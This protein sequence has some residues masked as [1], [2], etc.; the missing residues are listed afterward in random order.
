MAWASAQAMKP[1]RGGSCSSADCDARGRQ[2]KTESRSLA[3]T[4][5]GQ[6]RE[7]PRAAGIQE[8]R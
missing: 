6:G 7:V 5:T 3:G 8:P 4:L 2:R 1:P